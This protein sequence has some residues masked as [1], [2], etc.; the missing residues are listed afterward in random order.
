MPTYPL[1]FNSEEANLVM[2]KVVRSL[3]D[4]VEVYLIG[5]SIRNALYRHL[6]GK[7]LTQRDYDQ[8]ITKGSDKYFEYLM[9]LGFVKG[10]IDRPT[11]RVMRKPLTDSP[12]PESYNDWVVF[13]AHMVDGSTAMNNL[14]YHVGLTVNGFALSLRDAFTEDW[15][16]KLIMLPGALEAM[17][18]KQLRV[19]L[20]GYQD[21]A[22]NFFACLRFMSVGFA[23]PPAE[24]VKL[25]LDELPKVE[26]ERFD[27]NVQKVW[28]YVGGEENARKL[29]KQLG[30][31]VD[32]FDYRKLRS[33]F[34]NR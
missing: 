32:V 13:D 30:I 23:P 2:R 5:G 21:Q 28:R 31:D 17:K 27:R 12:D 11:Q 18:A 19:N 26:L 25:L 16:E 33:W 7:V 8:I 1:N 24:E 3:P 9:D 4:D 15:I 20:D 34:E 10:N 29:V 14:L 6:H 22:A